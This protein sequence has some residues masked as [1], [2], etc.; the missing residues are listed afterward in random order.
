MRQTVFQHKMKTWGLLLKNYEGF[1]SNRALNQAGTLLN[2]S[3]DPA[4]V[5]YVAREASRGLKLILG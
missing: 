1:Q 5:V 4:W 2:R 3:C